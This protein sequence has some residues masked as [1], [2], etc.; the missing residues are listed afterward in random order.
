MLKYASQMNYSIRQKLTVYT[1]LV[2][3]LA[4]IAAHAYIG[5]FSRFIADD[6]CSAAIA[7]SKGVLGG[8]LHWYKNWTGRFSANFLDSLM[9]Y[10]GP[11]ATP[12][13][14]SFALTLWLAALALA[15]YQFLWKIK[16]AMRA[17]MAALLSAAVSFFTLDITPDMAQSLYWG[18]GMRSV[19][20]PLVFAAA[21]A[22]LLMRYPDPGAPVKKISIAAGGLIAFIA[23]GFNE[24]Y[25]VLQICALVLLWIV[26]ATDKKRA[27]GRKDIFYLIAAGLAGA[28]IAALLIYLSPGNKIRLAWELK[29]F[30][31]TPAGIPMTLRVSA[32]AFFS[33]LRG[34]FLTWPDLLSFLGLVSFSVLAGAFLGNVP[35]DSGEE[36]A[37][38]GTDILL[39]LP[40]FAALLIFSCFIPAAYGLKKA[41][42]G[43]TLMIPCFVLVCAVLAWGYLAGALASRSLQKEITNRNKAGIKIVIAFMLLLAISRT[44]FAVYNTLQMRPEMSRYA[45]YWDSTNAFIIKARSNGARSVIIPAMPNWAGLSENVGPNP[46]DWANICAGDYYGGIE[47]SARKF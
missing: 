5:S 28:L 9:G 12:Y 42:P 15:A 47:I 1:L 8:T 34:M 32:A 35:S 23:A 3:F 36:G 38:R 40:V 6:Y 14:P 21:L 46:N 41:P 25:A 33:F 16:G 11:S 44:P 10:I 17:A 22:G 13:A 45:R 39:M 4:P 37:R 26:F 19:V 30:P 43:R 29:E 2:F 24:T 18:Q 27:A 7:Q 20:P 31:A